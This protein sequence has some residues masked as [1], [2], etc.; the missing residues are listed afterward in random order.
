[1][2][3]VIS[4]QL[5]GRT[6]SW[7]PWILPQASQLWQP[8]PCSPCRQPLPPAPRPEMPWHLSAS[9]ALGDDENWSQETTHCSKPRLCLAAPAAPGGPDRAAPDGTGPSR[10]GPAATASPGSGGTTQGGAPAP[11]AR[12]VRRRACA[13]ARDAVPA[14]RHGGCRQ[15]RPWGRCSPP[16]PLPRPAARA[17]ASGRW[18]CPIALSSPHSPPRLGSDRAPRQARCSRPASALRRLGPAAAV[19]PWCG[20]VGQCCGRS[21]RPAQGTAGTGP[22]CVQTH[23]SRARA[24]GRAGLG[25]RFCGRLRGLFGASWWVTPFPRPS[26][27][28]PAGAVSAKW[29]PHRSAVRA[30]AAARCRTR[31]AVRHRDGGT[32]VSV[33]TAVWRKGRALPWPVVLYRQAGRD[34]PLL[35]N[36]YFIKKYLSGLHVCFLNVLYCHQRKVVSKKF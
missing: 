25:P 23:A 32:D 30:A 16:S 28:C 35:S 17:P 2:L 10:A 3:C 4:T 26:L 15:V 21:V 13:P 22:E 18:A 8:R 33:G 29:P 6:H 11:R 24:A 12:K 7:R 31:C 34:V 5:P 9:D 20:A 36:I 19:P 27:L 1:M 14:P